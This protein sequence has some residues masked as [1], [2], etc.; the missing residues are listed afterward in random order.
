[1]LRF[2]LHPTI[3]LLWHRLHLALSRLLA[4]DVSFYI[5]GPCSALTQVDL[6]LDL[7]QLEGALKQASA[8]AG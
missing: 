4:P 8:A 2:S 1:M 7:G 3:A 6:E 5:G